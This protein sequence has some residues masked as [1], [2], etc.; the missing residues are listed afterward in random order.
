MPFLEPG[1]WGH[2]LV[3]QTALFGSV[4]QSMYFKSFC[5]KNPLTGLVD[6]YYRLVESYR[7][8][9]GRICHRVMLNIGFIP[10]LKVKQL[11]AI[12]RRLTNLVKGTPSLFEDSNPVVN[13]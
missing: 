12:Q 11:N 2:S 3:W 7:N 8:V 10:D 1:L 4:L 13:Q 6:G 5:R 9:E